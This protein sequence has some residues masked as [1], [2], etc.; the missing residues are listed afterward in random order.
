MK[1]CSDL[2][3][4]AVLISTILVP[5]YAASSDS[6]TVMT[7]TVKSPQTPGKKSPLIKFRLG[8]KVLIP[9]SSKILSSNVSN[10]AVIEVQIHDGKTIFVGVGEGDATAVI[11]VARYANDKVGKPEIFRFQVVSNTERVSLDT[12]SIAKG[13]LRL[14]SFNDNIL[15][16][17]STE[18]KVIK[19][20]ALNA[21]IPKTL[22]IYGLAPG[23]S[24]LIVVT[25]RFA[26]DTVGKS[27]SYQVEVQ[28]NSETSVA[29]DPEKISRLLG[30]T[31]PKSEVTFE[32]FLIQ[33][34]EKRDQRIKELE[35]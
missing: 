26:G 4:S 8:K 10:P 6:S 28:G 19:A 23:K 20:R 22:S 14:L 24:R 3:T 9:F 11:F 15:S 21:K 7:S 12:I 34:I 17:F 2:L 13:R 25:S 29:V 16:V 31:W 30:Q 1:I 27:Q 18:P 35:K 5:R 32:E 33:E